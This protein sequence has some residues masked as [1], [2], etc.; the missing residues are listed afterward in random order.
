MTENHP[1]TVDPET[2]E[3][4]PADELQAQKHIIGKL[5]RMKEV[6]SG[7]VALAEDGSIGAV[8]IKSALQTAFK[9]M[10]TR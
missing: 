4:T 10:F 6:I 7:L 8:Q 5:Y 2:G 3:M 9:K 1:A